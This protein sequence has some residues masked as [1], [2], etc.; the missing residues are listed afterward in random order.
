MNWDQ[1]WRTGLLTL[2]LGAGVLGLG[3]NQARG[4]WWGWGLGGFNYVAQ[5][6][7]FL[8][9]RALINAAG[10]RGPVSN[11]VY[12]GNPNSYINRVRD[13]GFVP[14][15]NVSRRMS[16][17]Q[18]PNPPVSPGERPQDQAPPRTV[19]AVPLPSFFDEARKLVWPGDAPVAGDLQR[20]RDISDEGSSIVLGELQAQGRATIAS[21]TDSR[22]KLLDY[23]Q[24]ALQEIR[25]RS[26]PP[27]AETF[28]SF[29]LSL[30]DSL[31]QAA[32][33]P[34]ASPTGSP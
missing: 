16:P 8:N 29:L 7:D 24:P 4:Y 21:V 1:R 31:A 28:H 26:T 33:P 19:N 13:N 12:A 23:G 27:V 25:A 15:Y 5:P 3:S 18:R 2:L 30:Y 9:Q 17:G 32:N 11:N 20:K 34:E 14:S 10:A 6:T 22:Q